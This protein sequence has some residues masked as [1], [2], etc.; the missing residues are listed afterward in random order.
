MKYDKELYS[1]NDFRIS[2]YYCVSVGAIF[3]LLGF[4]GVLDG[5]TLMQLFVGMFFF[6]SSAIFVHYAS[7][8]DIKCPTCQGKLKQK[9]IPTTPEHYL[10][11]GMEPEANTLLSSA[12]SVI[13]YCEACDKYSIDQ[14]VRES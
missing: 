11:K 7:T 10:H 1:G 12:S 2:T 6:F 4:M 9:Q 14:I 8:K 13:I 3:I 5:I